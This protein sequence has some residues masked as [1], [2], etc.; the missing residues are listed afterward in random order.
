ML[1]PKEKYMVL[2]IAIITGFVVSL[3]IV[4]TFIDF[5]KMKKFEMSYG[6][7]RGAYSGEVN[8]EGIP[9]G[10]V[11]LNSRTKRKLLIFTEENLWMVTLMAKGKSCGIMRTTSNM[12]WEHIKMMR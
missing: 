9:N 12:K 10:N 1:T 3:M 4:N 2:K 8:E 7:R 11:F 6:D 5:E